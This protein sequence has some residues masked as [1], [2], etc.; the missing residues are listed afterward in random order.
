M[1]SNAILIKRKR[2]L[3]EICSCLFSGDKVVFVLLAV[4]KC[5]RG[6]GI[7]KI[8]YKGKGMHAGQ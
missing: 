5:R 8:K 4:G 3:L 7:S 1:V 6:Y 2:Q